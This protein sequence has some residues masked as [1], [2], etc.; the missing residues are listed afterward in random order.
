L[1]R[2][3]EDEALLIFADPRGGSTWITELICELPRTALL[4]EPINPELVPAFRALNFTGPGRRQ[5]IPPDDSWPE[6][7]R[8]FSQLLEGK[9]M[10]AFLGQKI[11]PS[12]YLKSDQIIIKF[13][14][15][16]AIL[17]WLTKKFDLKYEPIYFIR[18]PFATVSSQLRHGA[19]GYEY[20]G[21][22]IPDC[23]HAEIY[24]RHEEFLSTLNTKEEELVALW[25]IS[26]KV[27]LKSERNNNDWIT[28]TYENTLMK[29]KA[30]LDRISNRWNKK[31]PKSSHKKVR[32]PSITSKETGKI[33]KSELQIGKWRRNLEKEQ[34]ER[35]NRVLNYFG[36]KEYN[37]RL[38]PKKEFGGISKNEG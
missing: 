11:T 15:G 12:K 22:S 17:P 7:R 27:P 30:T 16:S 20:N 4:W 29:P 14:K 28:V 21:F 19:W 6:A 37:E 35:M 3:P 5:Y 38:M 24:H 13:V 23:A 33:Y 34:I 36:I 10:N 1:K 26:N 8:V 18:H 9:I 25:A 2:F 32:K 31:I